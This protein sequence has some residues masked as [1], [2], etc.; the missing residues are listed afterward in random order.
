M[1]HRVTDQ[2]V[3]RVVLAQVSFLALS[4]LESVE[5]FGGADGVSSSSSS[6]GLKPIA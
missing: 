6:S 3:R 2:V 4:G 1:G 5:V